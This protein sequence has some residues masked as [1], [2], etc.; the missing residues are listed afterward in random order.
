MLLLLLPPQ[1]EWLL[2]LTLLVR[3]CLLRGHQ[4]GVWLHQ[5][6]R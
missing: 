1:Q 3:V 2:P 6:W 4:P 5:A